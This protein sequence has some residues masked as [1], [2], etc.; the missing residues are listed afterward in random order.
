MSGIVEA[1]RDSLGG[2]LLGVDPGFGPT[3]VDVAPA[4][5]VPALRAAREAGAAY[6]DFLTA[7]DELEQGFAVVAHVSTSDAAEHVLLR[8]R[9]PR[10]EPVLA[11]AVPVFR[12]LAWHERETH[13]LF[14]IR[15]EGHDL[16][17]LLVQPALGAHPL[18]KDFV[19]AARAARPWPGEK[20]PGDGG[21]AGAGARRQRRRTAPPGVPDGWPAA[22]ERP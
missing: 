13:D 15:F 18:T 10:D 21:E 19:L 1:L 14:G 5:W 2:D 22:G 12:G 7:Y 17:P 9:V 8:T 16:E 3:T 11:S 4:A 20:D 6:A